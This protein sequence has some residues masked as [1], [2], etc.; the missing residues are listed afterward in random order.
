[1]LARTGPEPH[2]R[3]FVADLTQQSCDFQ[4]SEHGFD[5]TPRE[6][7]LREAIRSLALGKFDVVLF[8]SLV[9]VH[10]AFRFADEMGE[11][12]EVTAGFRHAVV[13]SIGGDVENVAR[14]RNHSGSGTLAPEDGISREGDGGA[15]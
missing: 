13:G 14:V 12:P 10:H 3:D 4:S 8:T 15:K 11:H 6:A 1:V 5:Y 2:P 9:R 7:P